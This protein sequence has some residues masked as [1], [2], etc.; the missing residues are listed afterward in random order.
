MATLNHREKPVP[1]LAADAAT[2]GHLHTGVPPVDLADLARP[3]RRALE[4]P[5]GEERRSDPRKVVLE[6]GDP[7]PVSIGLQALAMTVARA[8][9]SAASIGHRVLPLIR[10]RLQ[11]PTS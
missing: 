7:T 5:G 6:D 8:V 4:G 2:D 10:P 9:G 3:V 1:S 11:T